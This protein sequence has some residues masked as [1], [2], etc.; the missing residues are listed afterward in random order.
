M[1]LTLKTFKNKSCLYIFDEPDTHFNQQWRSKFVTYLI[2]ASKNCTCANDFYISTHTSFIISD[3]SRENVRVFEKDSETGA[4]GV[5]LPSFQ[6]KGASTG[7]IN[8]EIF[9]QTSTIGANSKQELSEVVGNGKSLKDKVSKLSKYGDSVERDL[10]LMQI[11]KN[12]GDDSN[13]HSV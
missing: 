9:N 2:E 12:E 10:I 6:T 8:A 5:S 1:L 11:M 13:A 4:I 7:M 3:T